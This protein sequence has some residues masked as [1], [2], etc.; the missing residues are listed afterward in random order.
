MLKDLQQEFTQIVDH[1]ILLILL[2]S[3][4]DCHFCHEVRINYLSPLV[5]N[6]SNKKLVIRELQ[7]DVVNSLIG[8]DGKQIS[9]NEL[10][11][12]LKVNF[13]PTVVFLGANLE[14]LAEP[15]IG[16]NNSGFYGAYLDQ[17]I[18]IAMQSFRI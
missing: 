11:R 10:L 7:T 13:F 2:L 15:L 17:R 6:F 9:V 3:R 5:R 4:S 1:K 16:L 8:L 18:T 12:Q 14:M